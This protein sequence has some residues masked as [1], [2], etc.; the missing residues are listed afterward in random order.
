M[1]AGFPRVCVVVPCHNEEERIGGCL[2]AL[3]NQTYPNYEILVVD[4]ASTDNSPKIVKDNGIKLIRLETNSGVARA[5]NV[6]VKHSDAEIIAFTDGDC[7]VEKRWLEKLIDAMK[8]KNLD[9]VL[10]K[11]IRALNNQSYVVRAQNG[12][13]SIIEIGSEDL[14]GGYS[15][16]YKSEVI[17]ELGGFNQRFMR[18][19]EFD[20]NLRVMENRFS[21]GWAED[22]VVS[23]SYADTIGRLWK[24]RTADGFWL[25]EIMRA[26]P[27]FARKQIKHLLTRIIIIFAPPLYLFRM[28]ILWRKYENLKMLLAHWG[29]KYLKSLAYYLGFISPFPSRYLKTRRT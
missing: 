23:F 22:A 19:C 8:S 29:F 13:R 11:K 15:V 27:W 3:E 9:V 20:F 24:Q 4:D 28:F 12:G 10:G 16:A 14:G 26:H 6:G 18:G 5:R 21:L 7:V 25:K 17:K 1:A 2:R